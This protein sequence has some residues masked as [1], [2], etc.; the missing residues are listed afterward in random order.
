MGMAEQSLEEIMQ[1]DMRVL[2]DAAR[3]D[4]CGDGPFL[5]NNTFAFFPRTCC[6]THIALDK[7]TPGENTPR[8]DP[9]QHVTMC[10]CDRIRTQQPRISL[11]T[12]FHAI[13]AI[14]KKGGKTKRLN[15]AVERG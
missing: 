3:R 4:D 10:T 14:L 1:T 12:K 11:E 6:D 5:A 15:T 13:R 7:R 9:L 2:W 8:H